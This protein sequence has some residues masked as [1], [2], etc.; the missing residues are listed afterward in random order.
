M[1]SDANRQTTKKW[2][3]NP[4]IELFKLNPSV[5]SAGVDVEL[6]DG[7][8]DRKSSHGAEHRQRS[9][10]LLEVLILAHNVGRVKYRRR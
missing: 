5:R 2:L 10:R 6:H 8:V 7:F 9:V 4:L 1:Q 3:S